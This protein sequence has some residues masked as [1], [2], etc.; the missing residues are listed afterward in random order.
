[1][2]DAL[3]RENWQYFKDKHP[4]AFRAYEA[5]GKA[6]YEHGPLT[7]RECYLVKVAVAAASQYE[8]ALASLVERALEAGCTREEIEHT[9]LLTATTA[10]F[11]RMMTA[12]LNFRAMKT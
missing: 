3:R 9:I 4:E 5:L 7:E 6:I 8:Y 1:V 10:G 2:D 12:L 11:P